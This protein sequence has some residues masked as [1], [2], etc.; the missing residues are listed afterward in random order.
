[1]LRENNAS[2]LGEAAFQTWKDIVDFISEQGKI[3]GISSVPWKY[4]GE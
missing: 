3:K 4:K 2:S 1:M